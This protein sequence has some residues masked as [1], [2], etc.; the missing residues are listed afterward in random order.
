MTDEVKQAIQEAIGL[1]SA[2][3]LTKD[4]AIVYLQGSRC[5]LQALV[6]E[7]L[8]RHMVGRRAYYSKADINCLIKSM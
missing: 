8:E 6:D 3:Y 7:G 1:W 5:T 4:K 2:E